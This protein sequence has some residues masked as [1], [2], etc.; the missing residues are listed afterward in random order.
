MVVVGL[1]GHADRTHN[2]LMYSMAGK[3]IL[4]YTSDA[5]VKGALTAAHKTVNMN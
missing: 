5:E 3:E 4:A 1:R 2:S